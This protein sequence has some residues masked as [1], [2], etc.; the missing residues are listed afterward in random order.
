[1]SEPRRVLLIDAAAGVQAL[2]PLAQALRDVGAQVRE[3]RLEGQYGAVLDAIAQGW[4]PVVRK[5]PAGAGSG[6]AGIE[7]APPR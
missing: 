6:A 2:R 4:L 3:I 7:E 5:T 1:M